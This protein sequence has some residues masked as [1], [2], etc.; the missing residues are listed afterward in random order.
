MG[1]WQALAA[2]TLYMD[3]FFITL[4]IGASAAGE[5]AALADIL[6]RGFTILSY[7]IIIAGHP[8]IMR[9]WN[10]GSRFQAMDMSRL[11]TKRLA[12]LTIVGVIL[13]VLVCLSFGPWLLG[14]PIASAPT[15]WC[16]AFGAGCWQL[17]LMT[18]KGLE[19]VGR[20]RLM[21]LCLSGLVAVTI[22]VN[23]LFIPVWGTIVPA[24][25]FAFAAILYCSIT[26]YLSRRIF[27]SYRL[28]GDSS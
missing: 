20:P 7:P 1:I 25:S 8:A 17:S 3:R 26:F 13:G 18:H 9:A 10:M 28:Q 21:L 11:W 16:L 27:R 19:M 6:V 23:I 4:F 22:P 15:L 14:A 5:Y 2:A 24:A 12:L